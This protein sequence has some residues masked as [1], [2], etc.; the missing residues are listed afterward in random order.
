MAKTDVE[1]TAYGAFER[2]IYLILIPLVFTSILIGVMFALFDFD[3]KNKL[4]ASANEIPIIRAMVPDPEESPKDD[5]NQLNP[6][7]LGASTA[8]QTALLKQKQEELTQAIETIKQRDET[9]KSL[10]EQIAAAES[11]QVE[12]KLSKEAYVQRIQELANTYGKM[13]PSKAAPI[14]ENLTMPEIVLVLDQMKQT[15]QVRI[16]EKM[17]PQTA[18]EAS[19]LLKDVVKV[20]DQAI[21]A[22]QARL[23]LNVEPE[24]PAPTGLT[25][26]ELAQTVAG[27]DAETAAVVLLE[28]LPANESKVVEILRA[29][30]V[31]A[32]SQILTSIAEEN[33]EEAAILTAKLGEG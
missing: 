20:E 11:Q 26:A 10:Q 31:Q 8:E 19:I 1:K 28:M 4:L 21:E 30:N 14:I 9:I 33:K 17:N 25:Q 13:S 7:E 22:L 15:E 12:E 2:F 23:A 32:R 5:A 29:V 16:L 27:M 18:A 3:F 6:K 24:E